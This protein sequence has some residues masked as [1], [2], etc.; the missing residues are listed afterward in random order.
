MVVTL[1]KATPINVAHFRLWD[2]DNRHYRYRAAVSPDADG[3][4]WVTIGDYTAEAHERK[5]WQTVLFPLQVVRRIRV[6][7]TYNMDSSY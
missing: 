4:N 7:G 6:T 5:S 2:G 1:A 3:D